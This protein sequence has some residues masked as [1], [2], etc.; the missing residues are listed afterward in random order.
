MSGMKFRRTCAI[1]NTTF[2]TPDRRQSICSKCLKKR[3]QQSTASAPAGGQQRFQSR[4]QGQHSGSQGGHSH[5]HHDNRPRFQSR[6]P[7]GPGRG[8]GGGGGPRPKGRPSHSAPPKKTP[9]P[10]KTAVMTDELR[11]KIIDAYQPFQGSTDPLRIINAQ[12]SDKVWAKRALVMQVVSQVRGLQSP[13]STTTL[14]PEQ[15]QQVIDMFV[16]F[17]RNAERP[18]E[19]RHKAVATHLNIPV[20]TV[21]RVRRDWFKSQEGSLRELSRD[22]L[23]SIEKTYWN[24]LQRGQLPLDQLP[25][26]LAER[27]GF[28]PFQVM[29]WI[30]QL[31]ESE[32]SLSA[33]PETTPEQREGVISS[34]KEYLAGDKPPAKALHRT[35]GEKVGIT[36]NQVYKVLL[37]YRNGVRRQ[38]RPAA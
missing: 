28:S 38:Y 1:C 3:G 8:P 36:P 20:A 31:H 29:V 18:E 4:P 32:N 37:E 27:L 5:G 19:G 33:V 26:I 24:E 21:R 7:G 11:Q 10:P 35:I 15:M 16:K 30:D 2:F 25:E 13:A 12:I 34:Y 6:G 22:Q 23:F 14:T 17:I 9:K